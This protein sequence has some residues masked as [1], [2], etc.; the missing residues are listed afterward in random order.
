M[1][2]LFTWGYAIRQEARRGKGRAQVFSKQNEVAL[3]VD[4][5]WGWG[6]EDPAL[7]PRI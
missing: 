6:G 1:T 2:T 7:R 4:G 5:E 3:T